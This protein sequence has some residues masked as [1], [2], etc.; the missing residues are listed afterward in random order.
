MLAIT[1]LLPSCARLAA[2]V[3]E[4]VDIDREPGDVTDL[5]RMDAVRL[6]HPG[7]PVEVEVDDAFGAAELGDEDAPST[8]ARRRPAVGVMW[9]GRMPTCTR[10]RDRG[11]GRPAAV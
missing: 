11:R 10:R 6:G 1:R 4:A 3:E 2:E 9:C 8:A 7:A 5:E